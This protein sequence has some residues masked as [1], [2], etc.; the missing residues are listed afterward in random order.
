MRFAKMGFA[1]AAPAGIHIGPRLVCKDSNSSTIH[2][3]SK[4]RAVA[5]APQHVHL[6]FSTW[7][8]R[9][10]I[11]HHPPAVVHGEVGPHELAALAGELCWQLPLCAVCHQALVTTAY[12]LPCAAL[13]A[14]HTAQ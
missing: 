3:T 5:L 14:L 8:C 10:S 4:P 1:A 2:S 6:F 7:H 11:Q 13:P 9:A 12:V